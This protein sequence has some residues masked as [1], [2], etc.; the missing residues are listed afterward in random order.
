MLYF[1]SYR[2]QVLQKNFAI[3][4]ESNGDGVFVLEKLRE[5]VLTE[6]FQA[7]ISDVSSENVPQYFWWDYSFCKS[8]PRET[9]KTVGLIWWV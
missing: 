5:S 2:W 4:Q 8:F 7:N 1:R 3:L 6:Q 9:H